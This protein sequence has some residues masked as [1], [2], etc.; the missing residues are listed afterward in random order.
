MSHCFLKCV[1][2]FLMFIVI[3]CQ[4]DEPLHENLV[5]PVRTMMVP[6]HSQ[7]LTRVFPGKISPAHEVNLSFRVS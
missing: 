3:G 5:R 7:T 4:A 1:I 6:E 2:I